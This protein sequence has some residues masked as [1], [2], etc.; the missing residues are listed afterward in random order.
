MFEIK[1]E[2]QE[3]NENEK[4]LRKELQAARAVFEV[5]QYV[6]LSEVRTVMQEAMMTV[7]DKLKKSDDIA[8]DNRLKLANMGTKV[9]AC[10]RTVN[11]VGRLQ[12]STD[13]LFRNFKDHE[14]KII[15]QEAHHKQ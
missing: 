14:I 13:I 11:S 3:L 5:D 1:K 7:Y 15:E 9:E 12:S 6:K 2:R 8:R 10:L 4:K